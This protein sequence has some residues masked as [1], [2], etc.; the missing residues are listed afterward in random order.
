[1][2][3]VRCHFEQLKLCCEP[4]HDKASNTLLHFACCAH[5]LCTKQQQ[6]MFFMCKN[7]WVNTE[8]ITVSVHLRHL[9]D[10]TIFKVSTTKSCSSPSYR[11]TPISR[12]HRRHNCHTRIDKF[13]NCQMKHWR[14]RN[15]TGRM[16]GDGEERAKTC[17]IVLLYVI[18]LIMSKS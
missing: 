10:L 17:H 13:L 1:M 3:C 4:E 6:V 7:N 14:Q 5:S 11:S 16:R 9:C 2:L 18:Q 8:R 12:S 15:A